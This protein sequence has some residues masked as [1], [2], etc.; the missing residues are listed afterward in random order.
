MESDNCDAYLEEQ[1]LHPNDMQAQPFSTLNHV[2]FM[3][4]LN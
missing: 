2:F 1:V 4:T 3:P